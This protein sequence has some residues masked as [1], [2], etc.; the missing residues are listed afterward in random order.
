MFYGNVREEIEDASE[1]NDSI[2]TL[3]WLTLI[4]RTVVI[5][6]HTVALIS[7]TY[8]LHRCIRPLNLKNG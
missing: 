4:R 7:N 8:Y 1:L 2:N 5:I 3:I 6:E